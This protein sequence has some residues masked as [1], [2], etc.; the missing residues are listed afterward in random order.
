MQSN[1]LSLRDV[2]NHA[3][4]FPH[5]DLDHYSSDEFAHNR[6]CYDVA[7]HDA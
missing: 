5:D 6:I 3:Y 2:S 7:L 1:A 4:L